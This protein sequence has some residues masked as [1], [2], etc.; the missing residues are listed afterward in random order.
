[1]PPD[2]EAQRGGKAAAD[3]AKEALAQANGGGTGT[4]VAER[5]AQKSI[6]E[7][8]NEPAQK[9]QIALALPGVMTVERFTRICLTA[10]RA[11]PQLSSCSMTSL[12]AACMQSAQLGLEPG[13]LGQSYLVP[14]Y[15]KKAKIHEV[16]FI[17]GYQ[18]Y[19]D[20]FYRSG[21]VTSVV[22]REV[23]ENDEFTFHLGITDDMRHVPAET[24]RG[25][26]KRIYGLAR[27]E[28]GDHIL[29]VMNMEEI[30]ARR[31]RSKSADNG[32]WQTDATAMA[33]K[34]VIRAMVPYIP[35]TVLLRQALA[36]D[37][38]VPT[39]ISEDMADELSARPPAID[40]EE[41]PELPPTD[42]D[43]DLELA[44]PPGGAPEPPANEDGEQLPLEE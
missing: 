26:V 36:A 33:R 35:K 5:P 4:A 9:E 43:D 31:D 38:S 28:T 25:A 3:K 22:A 7:V 27:L 34:T 24:D 18:G 11:N 39:A 8:L 32:P 20:L 10:I 2:Q 12:L 16:Q 42:G 15:N 37:E 14:F 13:I 41:A 30:Y 17:I 29:H 1:M 21:M 6:L 44:G 19:L 23:C 40:V